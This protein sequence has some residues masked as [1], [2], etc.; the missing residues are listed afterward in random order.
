[1]ESE[2]IVA[3]RVSKNLYEKILKRQRAVKAL[4]GVDSTVSAVLRS[5]IEEAAENDVDRIRRIRLSKKR[6]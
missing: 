3:T 4:T 5:M 2:V 1:M 6:R